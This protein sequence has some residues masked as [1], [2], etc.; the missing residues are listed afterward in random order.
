M[1]DPRWKVAGE[2]LED[3][4]NRDSGE[5]AALRCVAAADP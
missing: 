3:V 4:P 1:A 2:R 5:I